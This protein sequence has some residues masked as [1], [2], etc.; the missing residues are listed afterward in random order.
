MLQTGQEFVGDF[1]R[2]L[3]DQF[4]GGAVFVEGD[5]RVE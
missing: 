2:P 1:L 5:K 4:I 3:N